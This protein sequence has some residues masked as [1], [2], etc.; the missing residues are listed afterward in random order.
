M[1]AQPYSG[2][3]Q[4]EECHGRRSLQPLDIVNPISIREFISGAL[5][6][7]MLG[8]TASSDPDLLPS[9]TIRDLS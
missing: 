1:Q 8:L 2:D 7:E 3:P 4:H 6:N 9:Y 5:H